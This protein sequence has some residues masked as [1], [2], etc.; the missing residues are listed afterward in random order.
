MYIYIAKG[1][2][3]E[4]RESKAKELIRKG[5][6]EIEFGSCKNSLEEILKLRERTRDAII[7][8]SDYHSPKWRLLSMKYLDKSK[9]V[10][11]KTNYKPIKKFVL[12]SIHTIHGISGLLSSKL[13]HKM[14]ELF[15]EY[16]KFIKN[17]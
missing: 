2:E 11:A 15:D 14:D 4:L 8:T 16:K 6:K 17:G 9:V 3:Y 7:V 5:Y 10:G 1:K 13:Y 12:Y